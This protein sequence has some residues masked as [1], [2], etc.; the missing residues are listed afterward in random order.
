M[1]KK[2]IIL[3]LI[4]VFL[5]G[6]NEALQPIITNSIYIQQMSVNSTGSA[7]VRLYDYIKKAFPVVYIT[8]ATLL[9]YKDT[10]NFIKEKIK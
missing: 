10:I 6:I 1:R 3:I 2:V 4:L 8:I 7:L 9:L 5:L